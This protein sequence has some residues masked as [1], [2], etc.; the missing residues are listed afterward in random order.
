M[1]QNNSL[2]GQL[3]AKS[4]VIPP[5]FFVP[6]VPTPG[7]T[8]QQFTFDGQAWTEDSFTTPGGLAFHCEY[9]A[10]G[11]GIIQLGDVGISGGGSDPTDTGVI[12][13]DFATEDVGN[14]RFIQGTT[15]SLTINQSGL[16]VASVAAP[17][18][19]VKPSA[20]GS[21]TAVATG[22]DNSIKVVLTTGTSAANGVQF[23]IA[24]KTAFPATPK[25]VVAPG[26]ANAAA[27]FNS[28]QWGFA[29]NVT[30]AGFDWTVPSNISSQ[31]QTF[32]FL[33]L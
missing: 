23:S 28:G 24:F 31:T 3:P 9:L 30:A 12:E 15:Q 25:I 5:L 18:A 26:D 19:T 33:V 2:G 4:T 10:W 13:I 8:A 29:T 1:A 7:F 11:G 32:F 14:F 22:T 20:G 6:T 21:A 17:T 27:V 16:R